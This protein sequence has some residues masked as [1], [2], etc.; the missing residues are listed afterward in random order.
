MDG[1]VG[2]VDANC[3]FGTD[4]PWGAAVQ[5]RERCLWVPVLYGGDGGIF[6]NPLCFS[7][8]KKDSS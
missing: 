8:H 3:P 2:L 4:G 7:N 1:E 5:H 6:I